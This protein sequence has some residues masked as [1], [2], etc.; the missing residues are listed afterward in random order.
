[1]K[2]KPDIE[3]RGAPRY[4]SLRPTGTNSQ[5][6]SGNKHRIWSDCQ[7]PDYLQSPSYDAKLKPWGT[8]MWWLNGRGQ[9][10]KWVERQEVYVS[11]GVIW[12]YKEFP[13]K[14][15]EGLIKHRL[16]EC[17]DSREMLYNRTCL[18][19]ERSDTYRVIEHYPVRIPKFTCMK[20]LQ[21][22]KN[23]VQVFE[24]LIG[25]EQRARKCVGQYHN[26]EI[27]PK[28]CEQRARKCVGQ[29]HNSEFEPQHCDCEGN[30][31]NT[32]PIINHSLFLRY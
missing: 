21:R 30:T 11:G 19:K 8:R 7:F 27:E 5:Q 2:T 15:C 6:K 29:Y 31:L 12:R 22:T 17:P 14:R 24:K 18:M 25:L 13:T 32:T 16:W 10:P 28:H 9:P 26:S 23:V 1:M 3:I 20:F 4:R